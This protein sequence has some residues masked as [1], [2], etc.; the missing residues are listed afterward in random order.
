MKK[1]ILT[2]ALFISV[3]TISS[4]QFTI[5][6]KAGLNLSKEYYGEKIVDEDINFNPGVNAG[7][8]GKYMLNDIFG[9][10]A[11]LL[12]SQQGFKSNISL[13]DYDGI[14]ISMG[15]KN[16]SHYLNIPLVFK[17]YP[18]KRFYI[19][20]GPQVGFCFSSNISPSDR[21]DNAP[22]VDY[23]AINFSLVG[24]LG[25]YLS[26]RLSLNARY[27][28]GLTHTFPDFNYK[29]RVLQFSLTYDL[30]DF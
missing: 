1:I 22:N 24:G 20:A 15:Y 29:S 7:L 5:G 19:E 13:M 10:Q 4:A 18:L 28:H 12:Y 17:Y 16:L 2:I 23:N 6:P 3:I 14:L 27:N 21:G 11:E 26:D 8:F 9:I 25:V 30:L